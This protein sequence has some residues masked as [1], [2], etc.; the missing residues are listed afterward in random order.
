MREDRSLAHE[1][2]VSTGPLSCTVS[3]VAIFQKLALWKRVNC[4][5]Y[6]L[7]SSPT[8]TQSGKKRGTIGG[9]S[10]RQLGR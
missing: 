3:T 2:W 5:S 8:R 1:K 9:D 7:E 10:G 6:V 4:A